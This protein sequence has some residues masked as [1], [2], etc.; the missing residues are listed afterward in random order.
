MLLYG[1]T[2]SPK[3]TKYSSIEDGD[4][5]NSTILTLHSH[6]GTHIDFPKHFFDEGC[7]LS[8]YQAEDFEFCHP[9][10]IDIPKGSGELIEKSDIEPFYTK[11]GKADLLLIKTGFHK[12]REQELYKTHNPGIHSAVIQYIRKYFKNMRA[13]GVDIVSVS[14]YQNREEGRKAH[15]EAFRNDK[16][17]GKPLLLIE[18]L[19]LNGDLRGINRVLVFPLFIPHLDAAPCTV[20]GEFENI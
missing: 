9:V 18:D 16:Q 19:N 6:T 14:S 8:D 10:L 20:V 17:F 11:M 4:S 15:K 7:C 13:I 3:I 1:S 5:S 12:F 2:P